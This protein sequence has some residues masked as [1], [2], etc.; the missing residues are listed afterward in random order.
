MFK[1]FGSGLGPALLSP[2]RLPPFCASRGRR[3]ASTSPLVP[4]RSFGRYQ[5]AEDADDAESDMV[6]R[7]TSSM[8]AIAAAAARAN[9][10][11]RDGTVSAK[12]LGTQLEHEAK[13]PNKTGNNLPRVVTKEF[14]NKV[15]RIVDRKWVSEDDIAKFKDALQASCLSLGLDRCGSHETRG[16]YLP[17]A[18][19]RSNSAASAS[20]VSP[21]FGTTTRTTSR[22]AVVPSSAEPDAEGGEQSGDDK[23]DYTE[24]VETIYIAP[25]P[26]E[27]EAVSASGSNAPHHRH[28]AN[29]QRGARALHGP[30]VMDDMLALI[31]SEFKKGKLGFGK[32]NLNQ[33]CVTAEA[34]RAAARALKAV[35]VVKEVVLN[36]EHVS[37]M[38]L[39]ELCKTMEHQ[40]EWYSEGGS[41]QKLR[42]AFNRA[43]VANVFERIGTGPKMSAEEREEFHK[44]V[45]RTRARLRSMSITS[46]F[47]LQKA[48]SAQAASAIP[49]EAATKGQDDGAEQKGEPVSPGATL[50]SRWGA[51]KSMFTGDNAAE[52]V[53]DIRSRKHV[54]MLLCRVEFRRAPASKRR[55][56]RGS[57]G[58]DVSPQRGSGKTYAINEP[59]S[60]EVQDNLANLCRVLMI[61]CLP[62]W[63]GP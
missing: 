39:K 33:R 59:I 43:M 4:V 47:G 23:D 48:A 25:K 63:D 46:S 35:P 31:D 58:R 38:V 11:Q 29:P 26:L 24:E 56:K 9:E 57:Q 13:N 2:S 32:L 30:S 62:T 22:V 44:E 18:K 19:G 50:R 40:V 8:A 15:F 7:T 53:A 51:V 27:S 3:C 14:F 6:R 1:G 36:S 20:H 16:S 60:Q 5:M 52:V 28:T 54:K 12:E 55:G 61:E 34:V 21:G 17:P 42:R 37:N 41:S 45:I 49:L 10:Q